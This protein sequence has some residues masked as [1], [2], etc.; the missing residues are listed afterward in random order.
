ME[1]IDRILLLWHSGWCFESRD[2]SGLLSRSGHRLLLKEYVIGWCYELICVNRLG[3]R[4]TR[5]PKLIKRIRG[6]ELREGILFD[7]SRLHD[8]CLGFL[9][10]EVILRFGIAIKLLESIVAIRP[11][12]LFA[13]T[14]TDSLQDLRVLG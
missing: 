11:A 3:V 14:L 1:E 8:L 9:E 6:L 2:R 13:G 12:V 5:H 10:I 7:R 4:G